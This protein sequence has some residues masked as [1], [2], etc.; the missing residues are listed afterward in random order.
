MTSLRFEIFDNFGFGSEPTEEGAII[1]HR[2]RRRSVVHELTAAPCTASAARSPKEIDYLASLM[3]RE[4][5]NQNYHSRQKK[6]TVETQPKKIKL[7]KSIFRLFFRAL[8][9]FCGV[10]GACLDGSSGA[11]VCGKQA[12]TSS[13]ELLTQTQSENNL[14]RGKLLSNSRK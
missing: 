3:L 1:A 6:Q 8:L 5:E 13:S 11:G 4:E 12:Q 10:I 7:V 9:G 14:D 2:S